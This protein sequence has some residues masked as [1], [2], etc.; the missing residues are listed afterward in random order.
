MK[1]VPPYGNRSAGSAEWKRE[2]YGMD[3]T[4]LTGHRHWYLADHPAG[5]R[6]TMGMEVYA[7][8]SEV[9]GAG[10]YL[11]FYGEPVGA[12]AG[13]AGAAYRRAARGGASRVSWG[14]V[15]T[16]IF[17]GGGITLGF[18]RH[19]KDGGMNTISAG[20]MWQVGRI[21]SPSI[22]PNGNTCYWHI[23]T[24]GKVRKKRHGRDE[25]PVRPVAWCSEIR[26][27]SG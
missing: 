15:R 4:V 8:L 19:P 22:W 3:R 20:P 17:R 24:D 18:L 14:E 13:Y 11:F 5:I 12:A 7:G 23:T 9:S 10:R 26:I 2:L 27:E 21:C 16:P 6:P 1:W 25:Y